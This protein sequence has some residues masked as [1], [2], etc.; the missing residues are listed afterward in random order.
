M[1]MVIYKNSVYSC[2][3]IYVYAYVYVHALVNIIGETDLANI[4]QTIPNL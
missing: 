3:F 1:K 4:Y 2:E